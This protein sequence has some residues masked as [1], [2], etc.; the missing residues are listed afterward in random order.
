MTASQKMADRPSAPLRDRGL[1]KNMENPD[2][3][4]PYMEL[5]GDHTHVYL[6]CYW[7]SFSGEVA[8][9]QR[10]LERFRAA[11]SRRIKI[12]VLGNSVSNLRKDVRLEELP[13]GRLAGGNLI[14]DPLELLDL[15]RDFGGYTFRGAM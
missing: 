14:F 9:G 15:D 11:K 6:M 10:E 2:E 8:V 7:D 4:S 3:R 12:V 13:A 5:Y 1:I